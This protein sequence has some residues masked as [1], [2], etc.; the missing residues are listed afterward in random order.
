MKGV[1]LDVLIAAPPAR[2]W[3]CLTDPASVRAWFGPHMA[4]DARPGGGFREVWRDGAR[5]VVT[6]GRVLAFDPPSRLALSWADA[7]WPAETLVTLTLRPEGAGT[8][9]HL[10]HGGWE[11]LGAGDEALAAA[12]RAGWQ[13]HLAALAAYAGQ[14]GAEVPPPATPMP[15]R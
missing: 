6:A 5:E 12:H 13:G 10:T 7:D 4:L 2:V 8:R 1:D 14:K 9:L 15:G 11:A 3:S